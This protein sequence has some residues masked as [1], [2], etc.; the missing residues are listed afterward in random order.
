[1][2]I[3][4]YK[5]FFTKFNIRH[6]KIKDIVFE[7]FSWN[8]MCST[9]ATVINLFFGKDNG[10]LNSIGLG[11]WLLFLLSLYDVWRRGWVRRTRLKFL[12]KE[13]GYALK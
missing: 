5:T 4:L 2:R 7:L 11:L 8:L 12:K 3:F 10:I 1:M 13:L 6:S 9:F